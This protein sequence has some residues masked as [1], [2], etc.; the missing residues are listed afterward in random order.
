MTNMSR[1]W[2]LIGPFLLKTMDNSTGQKY[3]LQERTEFNLGSIHSFI[4][5]CDYDE[6]YDD[7]DDDDDHD[8]DDDDDEKR[9]T[10]PIF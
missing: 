4:T 6:E 7:D 10:L 2:I 9:D 1:Y 8:D 3:P 5:I